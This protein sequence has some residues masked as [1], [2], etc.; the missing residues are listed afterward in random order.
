MRSFI[1]FAQRLFC[2]L[3]TRLGN[4]CFILMGKGD[5]PFVVD[6]EFL[7]VFSGWDLQEYFMAILREG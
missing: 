2:T 5:L 7:P 1:D 6:R 4:G 3:R